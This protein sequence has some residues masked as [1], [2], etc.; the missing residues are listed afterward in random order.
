M[1]SDSTIELHMASTQDAPPSPL[2]GMVLALVGLA[3][4]AENLGVEPDRV[5]G[6][7][8]PWPL[9]LLVLGVTLLA[10]S[11]PHSV[12]RGLGLIVA[13][14][15]VWAGRAHLLPVPFWHLV[16]PVLLAA[17]GGL[18]LWRSISRRG[19]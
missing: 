7:L 9:L 12:G 3:W 2:L 16:A 6:T 8:W 11:S 1:P 19:D 5:L 4:L 14:L 10:G 17:A 18:L 15:V 13:G